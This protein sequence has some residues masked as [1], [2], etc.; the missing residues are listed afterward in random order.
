M[1]QGPVPAA[2]PLVLRGIII[3]TVYIQWQEET[4]HTI[5]LRTAHHMELVTDVYLQS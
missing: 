1:I 4:H 5:S 2:W 3:I